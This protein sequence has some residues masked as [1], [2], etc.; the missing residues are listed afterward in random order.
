MRIISRSSAFLAFS[1]FIFSVAGFSIHA[2]TVNIDA[3]KLVSRAEVFFSPRT[4]SF[5]EG[6]TFDVPFFINTKGNNVNGVEIRIKFDSDK[7]SIVRHSG[8][9]SIIGVWV[10]PPVYDNT[11]GTA[12]YTGVIPGGLSTNS[13]LIGSITFKAKSAG[14]AT[15][16]FNSN[17]K[18]LLNDGLGTEAL[19]DFG[20][21][22]YTILP[23]APEGEAIFSETHPF[24]DR[25]Y[26]N[27]SPIISWDQSSVVDG[28]SFVL[29]NKPSTIPE[30]SIN[31][32]ET[33]QSFENLD[34]GLWYFHLKTKKNGVWG[35]TGH[36]LMRID[37]VPPA[38]FKPQVSYLVAATIFVEQTLISF[39]TTDNLSGVDY[40]EVGVIDKN[41]PPT[42]SP[43]F[44]Q[45]ESPFQVALG[46]GSNLRVIVRAVDR[47]GN[48][49]DASLNVRSPFVVGTFVKDY[50]VYILVF[51]ILVGLAG[52]IMH[53]LFGH[54]II[55]KVR[56][57]VELVK[58]AYRN[59]K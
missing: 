16:S 38:N 48:I 43:V 29:D 13:G 20:R 53:Y 27:N 22:D 41:Q 18:V 58:K 42:V 6:G 7:L 59:R 19:V 28:Y 1:L 3:S 12:S 57:I 32:K 34:D 10:E 52:L 49:R 55:K 45:A 14:K 50:I 25:W 35:G 9:T 21:G 36:F 39:F 24:Q 56:H 51:I 37:T 33:T 26:N 44:V 5:S 11:R 15:V 54:H 30:N 40:Y 46:D 8:G 31:T 23:K 4:G 47:A 2:Q 17:S